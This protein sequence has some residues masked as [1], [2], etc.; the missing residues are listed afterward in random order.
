MN[1]VNVHNNDDAR[2]TVSDVWTV[3][4]VARKG[5]AGAWSASAAAPTGNAV[6][7]EEITAGDGV[8][9][10][11][12]MSSFGRPSLATIRTI[13]TL[14]MILTT[15]RGAGTIGRASVA[16]VRAPWFAGAVIT[17]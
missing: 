7:P 8:R 5:N 12:S 14:T 10:E 16:N 11:A 3:S 2:K 9:V 1:K 13:T 17:V 4:D 15:L 6:A